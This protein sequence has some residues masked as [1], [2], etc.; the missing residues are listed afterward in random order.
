MRGSVC[1]ENRFI[2]DLSFGVVRVC[3]KPRGATG[4]RGPD[5]VYT[6]EADQVNRFAFQVRA[7]DA[8]TP[9][10]TLPQELELLAENLA[11]CQ[12]SRHSG[13]PTTRMT[14]T[15]PKIQAGHCCGVAPSIIGWT[16]EQDLIESSLGMIEVTVG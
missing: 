5:R 16:H 13:Y 11:G 8:R 9:D 6:N 7:V 14:A 4:G 10:G 2:G 12:G 1:S 3:Q 15:S